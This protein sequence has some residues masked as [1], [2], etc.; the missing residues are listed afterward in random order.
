MTRAVEQ[1]SGQPK[2][3]RKTSRSSGKC[4]SLGNVDF[5]QKSAGPR[6]P[7]TFVLFGSPRTKKNHGRVIKRGGRKFHIQSEAYEAWNASAQSQLAKVRSESNVPLPLA[8]QVNCRALFLRDAER[9]DAV[10]YYQGLADALQEGRIIEDDRLVV[11]W[12]GSR[13]LKDSANPRV[14]VSLEAA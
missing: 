9:G 2:Q 12:D 4:N 10:G 14:I 3:E 1:A 11:S 5:H 7:M 8:F 6:V 13:I